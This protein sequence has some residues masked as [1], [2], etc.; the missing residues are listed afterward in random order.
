MAN[1][2]SPPIRNWAVM[3][4]A[5]TAL[6]GPTLLGVFVDWYWKT[7]PWGTVIG[8]GLGLVSCIY[9]LVQIVNRLNK[10]ENRPND[11]NQ[12]K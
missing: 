2:P 8:I 6:T 10:T 4:Q 5:G 1:D 7:S 11:Q 3:A 9:Q 12:S